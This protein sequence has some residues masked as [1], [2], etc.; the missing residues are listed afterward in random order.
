[1][2]YA[3]QIFHNKGLL[4]RVKDFPESYSIGRKDIHLFPATFN[5][6]ISTK[7]EKNHA[8]RKAWVF[9]DQ[10]HRHSKE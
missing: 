5:F 10:G 7:E 6:P 9:T 2:K 8:N 3:P 4:F 1:M